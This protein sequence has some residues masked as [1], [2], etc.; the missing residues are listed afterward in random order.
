MNVIVKS[1]C[2]VAGIAA[3]LNFVVMKSWF[4]SSIAVL[5]G[6]VILLM[7]SGMSLA[8]MVCVKSGHTAITLNIPDDCCK[9]E[10]EH[11]PANI[12]EKCCDVS[13]LNVEALQY[14][15]STQHS[16]VKSIEFIELP[17]PDRGIIA[18]EEI[19]TAQFREH[20]VP[21]NLSIPPVR[22]FTKSFQI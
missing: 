20:S 7:G 13:S 21:E 17:S 14:L 19:I 16:I 2:A 6:A 4:K 11:A 1:C 10:H 15:N 12:E 18:Y 8:K 22:I 9:H 5:L 3:L